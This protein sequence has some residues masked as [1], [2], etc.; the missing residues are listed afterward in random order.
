MITIIVVAHA[1]LASALVTAA[2]H[3]YSRDPCAAS[4]K[5]LGFDVA[6]DAEPL[7]TLAQM[8]ALLDK[9]DT[10]DGVLVLTD[11][12]GASPANAAAQLARAGR[13]AV[14]AGVNLPMLLRS[15]CYGASGL[16]ALVAKALA[17]GEQGVRQLSAPAEPPPGSAAVAAMA[18]ADTA[19]R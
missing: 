18:A 12:A 15:L 14:V 10:G 11:V 3:V 1:P 2:K 4:H 17:G 6:A 8:R 9:A 16:D 19:K 13:V 7:A 5:M